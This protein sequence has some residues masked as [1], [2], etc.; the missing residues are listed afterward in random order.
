MYISSYFWFACV[1]LSLLTS[2]YSSHSNFFAIVLRFWFMRWFEGTWGR[3]NFSF[4]STFIPKR[5]PGFHCV[6]FL[7]CLRKNWLSCCE[8]WIRICEVNR[9]VVSNRHDV[10]RQSKHRIQID[11]VYAQ[12]SISFVGT[13]FD[14]ALVMTGHI[15]VR[16]PWK[17]QYCMINHDA[18]NLCERPY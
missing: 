1:R 8:G 7:S 10:D 15:L 14:Q 11:F 16:V 9:Q 18:S 12:V 4:C 3:I 2:T 6:H 13:S 17:R 5:L